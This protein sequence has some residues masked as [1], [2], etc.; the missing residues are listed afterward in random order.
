[1]VAVFKTC[2][3]HILS[4]VLQLPKSFRIVKYLKLYDYNRLVLLTF[5]LWKI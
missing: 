2:I 5:N 4:D 3:S 1:M